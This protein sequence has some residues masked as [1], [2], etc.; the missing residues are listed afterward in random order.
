MSESVCVCAHPCMCVCVCE[1]EEQRKCNKDYTLKRIVNCFPVDA[2]DPHGSLTG[3]GY[4]HCHYPTCSG[5]GT[6]QQPPMHSRHPL[7]FRGEEEVEFL[8]IVVHA[9]EEDAPCVSLDNTAGEGE[10]GTEG[11]CEWGVGRRGG[12]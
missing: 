8:A 4:P 9:E 11:G 2:G 5:S 7:L 1:V 10:R 3:K 12:N 6:H